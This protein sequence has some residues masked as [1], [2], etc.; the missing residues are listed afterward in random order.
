VVILQELHAIQYLVNLLM[1]MMAV[2]PTKT[3]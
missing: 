3:C 1:L 2:W